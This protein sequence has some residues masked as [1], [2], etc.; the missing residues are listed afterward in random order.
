V[1]TSKPGGAEY[2]T[3]Q[4]SGFPEGPKP[5]YYTLV[6]PWDDMGEPT[7]PDLFP[8]GHLGVPGLWN[9]YIRGLVHVFVA[10]FSILLRHLCN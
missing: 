1:K 9:V 3:I 8:D 4:A 5:H 6:R 2:L 7:M 10:N